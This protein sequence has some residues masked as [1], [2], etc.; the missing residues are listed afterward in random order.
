MDKKVYMYKY[1]Y[2]SALSHIIKKSV[3]VNA[4]NY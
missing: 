1:S 4:V 2:F 3:F